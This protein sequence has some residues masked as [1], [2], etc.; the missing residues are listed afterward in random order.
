MSPPPTTPWTREGRVAR[1]NAGVLAG[2]DTQP[3]RDCV[4]EAHMCQLQMEQGKGL[5]TPPSRPERWEV[6]VTPVQLAP[7]RHS[8]LL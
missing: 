3:R 7:R 1:Y 2:A 6:V 4:R 5:L 8:W